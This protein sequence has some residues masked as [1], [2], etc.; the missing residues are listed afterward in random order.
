MMECKIYSMILITTQLWR[1]VKTAPG[2]DF[3]LKNWYIFDHIP[4]QI[5]I[6]LNKNWNLLCLLTMQMLQK[7]CG[8]TWKHWKLFISGM[9]STNIIIIDNTHEYNKYS[10]NVADSK[11]HGANM[12]PTWVLSAPDGPNVGPMNL[13]IWVASVILNWCPVVSCQMGQDTH[14]KLYIFSH[15]ESKS[16]LIWHF[17]GG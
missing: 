13:A 6:L 12:G 15:H 1:H 16:G 4:F 3:Y 10:V 9:S 8:S 2:S 11:V 7:V 17:C 5:S 14:D